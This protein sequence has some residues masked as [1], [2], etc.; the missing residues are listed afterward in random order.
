MKGYGG[1]YFKKGC[2]CCET[3]PKDKVIQH[4]SARKKASIE[5]K[6]EVLEHL[7]YDVRPYESCFGSH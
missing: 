6:K 5:I 3:S 2:E 1:K 7:G 4:K